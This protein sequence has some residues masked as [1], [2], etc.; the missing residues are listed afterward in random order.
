M[1]QALL[2]QSEIDPA[3]GQFINRDYS[4]Y[5][6]PTSADILELDVLFLGGFCESACKKDPLL[7]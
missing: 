2:E 4:G 6:V 3:S 7:G 5:L 1:G